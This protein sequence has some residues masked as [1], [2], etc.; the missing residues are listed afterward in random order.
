[1]HHRS[2]TYT[3]VFSAEWETISFEFRGCTGLF[4]FLIILRLQGGVH[5]QVTSPLASQS[6][7]IG[8]FSSAKPSYWNGAVDLLAY[9]PGAGSPC[10]ETL[11]YVS[12]VQSVF[13]TCFHKA[14]SEQYIWVVINS[15]SNK[16][17][18]QKMSW[19]SGM[20]LSWVMTLSRSRF[21]RT[22]T[23]GNSLSF[24]PF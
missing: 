6:L 23:N 5:S 16:I 18:F 22:E 21:K 1:M 24:L 11:K 7:E 19:T 17:Y 4:Y 14:K 8:V 10:W 9:N 13:F 15:L 20:I 3:G 12:F 2:S